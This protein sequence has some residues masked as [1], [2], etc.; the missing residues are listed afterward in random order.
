[1]QRHPPKKPRRDQALVKRLK[2]L[3]R[4]RPR[5]GYRRIHALLVRE[6]WRVNRKRVQRLW[7]E[8]GLKVVRRQRK[9]GR[10]GGAG[11]GCMRQR[12]E[13]KNHVWSYDF[14]M[15]QTVD[16]RRLKL[17]PVVDEHTREALAI[18]V[19][20]S[21]TAQD[22]IATLTYLFRVHGEPEYIRSD[23]GPEFIAHAVKRWLADSG[24]KTLYI[25]PGSPW[26]NAYVES[27]SGTM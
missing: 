5:Y 25:E 7:R 12:A 19:E 9:R 6:G 18:D 16:G 17:M 8:A 23:N 4:R 24:V 11:N 26:Q 15:D 10:L 14:T 22:V 3:S 2:V 13:R 21:M 1:M 27:G 20:R